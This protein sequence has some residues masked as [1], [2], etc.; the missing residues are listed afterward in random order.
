M[1]DFG[2][3]KDAIDLHFHAGPDI[4]ARRMDFLEMAKLAAEVG[5]R[6][7]AY[8]PI[9]FCTMDKAYGAEKIVSGTR[10]FGGIIL[11][12]SVG[13]LNPYAV[14]IAIR[15]KAKFIH[16]PVADSLHTKVRAE[17]VPLYKGE[18]YEDRPAITIFDSEG[19]LKP[20]VIKIIEIIAKAKDVVLATGHL[21]PEESIALIG[22]AKSRGIKY[23]IA[24]HASGEIIGAT[25]EQQKIMAE[26]GAFIEHVWSFCLPR[27]YRQGQHP[28]EIADAIKAVGPK[29]C[30]LATDLG[31]IYYHPIDGFRS[32]ILTMKA[33]GISDDD[34]NIMTKENPAKILGL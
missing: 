30:V 27:P 8:K 13:G 14:D 4:P 5:M 2:M 29:H 11:N 19:K 28:A 31:V 12:N 34:L 21:S 25:I 16:M 22:E 9:N 32:F 15:R 33:L 7:V 20:E 6:A 26:K 23:V 17:R 1:E 18:V 10:F 24:C 3:L